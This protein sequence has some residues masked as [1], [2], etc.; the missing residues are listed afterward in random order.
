MLR[1]AASLMPI[2][3][4]TTAATRSTRG[5]CPAC[6]EEGSLEGEDYGDVAIDYPEQFGDM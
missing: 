4:P 3:L 2:N 1:A 5:D 6:G